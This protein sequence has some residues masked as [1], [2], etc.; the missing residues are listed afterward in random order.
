MKFISA[1]LRI[2]NQLRTYH[3]LCDTFSQHRAYGDTYDAFS[4]LIDNFVET[5]MGK[6][7]KTTHHITYNI[8]IS[9]NTETAAEFIESIIEFL[10]SLSEHL[11]ESDTDLLNIRDEMLGAVNKLKYLLSLQ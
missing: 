6:Y 7:G 9:T 2:H 11:D 5:H 10:T 4:E 8:E 3:W 1:L